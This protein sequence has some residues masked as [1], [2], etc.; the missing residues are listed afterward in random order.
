MLAPQRAEAYTAGPHK[1]SVRRLQC[2][3]ERLRLPHRSRLRHFPK[4]AQEDTQL[5]GLWREDRAQAC[6]SPPPRRR[7]LFSFPSALPP[8]AVPK[9]TDSSVPFFPPAQ[10]WLVPNSHV[11]TSQNPQNLICAN[12][13]KQRKGTDF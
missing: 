12:T 11:S 8:P 4:P 10:G 13:E 2:G 6:I 9:A 7:R 5:Q 3:A 1:A